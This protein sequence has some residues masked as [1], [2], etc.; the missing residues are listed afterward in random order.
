M[1]KLVGL[2]GGSK[3]LLNTVFLHCQETVL[4][5][6]SGNSYGQETVSRLSIRLT[7]TISVHFFG[8]TREGKGEGDSK[9][10]EKSES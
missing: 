8:T 7:E 10:A 3:R 9:M 1:L 5:H 4:F 2:R 6:T